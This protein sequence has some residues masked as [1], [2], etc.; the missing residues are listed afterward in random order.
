MITGA[1]IGHALSGGGGNSPGMMPMSSQ[2]RVT[3]NITRNVTVV[4]AP[5]PK[6]NYMDTSKFKAAAPAPAPKVNYMNT[7]KFGK[8]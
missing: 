7:A 5:A 4:A 3:N 6:T 8:R 2:P 1:L